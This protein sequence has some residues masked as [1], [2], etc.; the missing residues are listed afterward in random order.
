MI[1]KIEIG[2]TRRHAVFA[3]PPPLGLVGLAIGC[4]ALTP[5]TSSFRLTSAGLSA[6]GIDFYEQVVPKKDQFA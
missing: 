2:A 6:A 3:E 1:G 4:A 5:I